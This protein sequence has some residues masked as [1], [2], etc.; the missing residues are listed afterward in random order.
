MAADKYELKKIQVELKRVNAGRE[1]QELQIMDLEQQIARTQA[2]VEVS[3]A[4]EVELEA[5]IAEMLKN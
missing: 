4:R 1:G 2:S 3:L 5:K